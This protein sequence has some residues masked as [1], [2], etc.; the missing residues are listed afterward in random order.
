MNVFLSGSLLNTKSLT[1]V[2]AFIY[3]QLGELMFIFIGISGVSAE[4]H[5]CAQ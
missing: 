4:P 2:W 5:G 3:L 1:F